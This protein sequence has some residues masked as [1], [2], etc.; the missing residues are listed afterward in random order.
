M[1]QRCTVCIHPKRDD[2]SR[3][4]LKEEQSMAV[5]AQ[6]YGLS[7]SAL[8]RHKQNHLRLSPGLVSEAANALTI[9]G[10]AHSLYERADRL[11]EAAERGLDGSPRSVQAAAASVREV[12]ASID[13]LAR[14]VVTGPQDPEAQ[15]DAWLDAAIT[16]AVD[17][18][19][20]PALSPPEDDV[21][22]AQVVGDVSQP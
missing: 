20:V 4:L 5:L 3:D 14:L 7:A 21:V 2:I 9:V 19:T 16:A 8:D 18:L 1:T 11:L 15:P 10:Y 17:R 13:L 6:A 22:D 12:R